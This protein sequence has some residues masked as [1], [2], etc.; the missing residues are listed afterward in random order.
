MAGTLLV[1]SN[2]TPCGEA[3]K[4][5]SEGGSG[6]AAGHVN[7]CVCGGHEAGGVGV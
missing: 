2:A 5:A 6:H 1:S 3:Q 4:E 7:S